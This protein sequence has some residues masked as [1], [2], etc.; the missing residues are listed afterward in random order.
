M[1]FLFELDRNIATESYQLEIDHDKSSLLTKSVI[2][3][4]GALDE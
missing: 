1:A 3:C 2:A 4:K